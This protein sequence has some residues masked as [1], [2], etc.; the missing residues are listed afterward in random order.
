MKDEA[1]QIFDE[2]EEILWDF[3]E[4][5]VTLYNLLSMFLESH[6]NSVEFC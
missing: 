6:V 5:C 3:V 2:L 1:R 4:F